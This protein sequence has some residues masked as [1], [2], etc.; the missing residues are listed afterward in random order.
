MKLLIHLFLMLTLASCGDDDTPVNPI[1]IKPVPTIQ[2]P[3]LDL[4]PTSPPFTLDLSSASFY[5]DIAYDTAARNV[6]DFFMPN[7]SAPSALLIYVHGG[8][9]VSGDKNTSLYKYLF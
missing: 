8:G 9:F 5:Q 4:V 3:E 6:F 7:N 1:I 2:E